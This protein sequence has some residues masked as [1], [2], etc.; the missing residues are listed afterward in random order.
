MITDY[1]DDAH[2]C[3]KCHTTIIGLETYVNHR[4]AG[5]SK[6]LGDV[7]KSPLPSQLLPPDESFNLKADDFFSSLELRSSSKKNETQ[8]TSNRNFSGILTRSKTSA[9]IQATS[10]QLCH[11]D[12]FLIYFPFCL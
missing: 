6:N 1:E 9:V 11:L 10:G 7:P 12:F 2:F 4:K 3:L 8:S 5:C